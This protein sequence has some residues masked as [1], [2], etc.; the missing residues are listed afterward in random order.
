MTT[1][2]PDQPAT[3]SPEP[4]DSMEEADTANGES[5]T[6]DEDDDKD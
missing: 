5:G 1:A 4:P 6:L 2:D 3:D